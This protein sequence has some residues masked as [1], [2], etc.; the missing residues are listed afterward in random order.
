MTARLVNGGK[1]VKPRLV[2]SIED[3]GSQI[4]PA[5]LIG[6]REKNLDIVRRGM[7]MVVNE[8]RGTAHGSM[9]KEAPYSMGGKTGSAQVRRITESMRAQ[10]LASADTMP[11]KF[12][13]HALFVGFGPVE[14]PQ[15]ACAVI[16]EHGAHGASTAAPIARDI[17][18]AAQKRDPRRIRTV[19]DTVAGKEEK[20]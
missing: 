1:E 13:D 20:K 6:F 11:W 18:L 9:I 15:Y 8:P 12:R 16:V 4:P 5:P 17:L 3:V 2:R 14:A 7:A 10:G 19:D